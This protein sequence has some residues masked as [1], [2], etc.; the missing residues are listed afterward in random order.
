[1]KPD[2]LLGLVLAVAAL[3]LAAPALV[4]SSALSLRLMLAL[5]G[6]AVCIGLAVLGPVSSNVPGKF[7]CGTIVAPH[8]R[9]PDGIYSSCGPAISNAR[10][11]VAG[12]LLICTLV[13]ADCGYRLRRDSAPSD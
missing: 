9:T 12:L 2:V 4:R 8:D 5:G 3:I 6:V 7:S 1:M 11:E 10:W 13:A